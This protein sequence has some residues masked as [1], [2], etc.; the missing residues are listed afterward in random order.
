MGPNQ[1][2]STLALPRSP[3]IHPKEVNVKL[4]QVW[5]AQMMEQQ[6]GPYPVRGPAFLLDHIFLFGPS[7][8]QV[9]AS[10]LWQMGKALAQPFRCWRPESMD[11]KAKSHTNT[12]TLWSDRQWIQAMARAPELL[13]D[14]Q[15]R[16]SL[17]SKE[18]W[19]AYGR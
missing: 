10:E 12:H 17:T 16:M 14:H 6:D 5:G 13:L 18:A 9:Q 19:S 4:P 11:L 8:F 15:E 7:S 3:D 1:T 2:R